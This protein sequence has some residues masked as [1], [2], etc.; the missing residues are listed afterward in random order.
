VTGCV[1]EENANPRACD[2]S[3]SAQAWETCKGTGFY[4]LHK[5]DTLH[6]MVF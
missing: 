5:C 6:A 3:L 1:S 2:T 4:N